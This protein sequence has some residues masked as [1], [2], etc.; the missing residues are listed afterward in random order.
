MSLGCIRLEQDQTSAQLQAQKV[1]R[2]IFRC[3]PGRGSQ[4]PR[5]L[6]HILGALPSKTL[7]VY[8]AIFSY[9]AC[10]PSPNHTESLCILSLSGKPQAFTMDILRHKDIIDE[11]VTSGHKIMTTSSEEE[12]QSM[13]VSPCLNAGQ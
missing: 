10:L 3:G 9:F 11:L 4:G 2:R 8:L 1:N 12:K 13:K 6:K 7:S 5:S